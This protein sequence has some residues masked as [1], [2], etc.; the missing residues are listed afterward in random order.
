MLVGVT[1]VTHNMNFNL[2]WLYL[3]DPLNVLHVLLP[4]NKDGVEELLSVMGTSCSAKEIV[5]TTQELSERLESY[6]EVEDSQAHV[7]CSIQLVR[8]MNLYA[9]G[10]SFSP[11]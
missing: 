8:I 1:N 11:S 4:S 9:V 10:Q 2:I 7:S 6:G 3:Q 5:I